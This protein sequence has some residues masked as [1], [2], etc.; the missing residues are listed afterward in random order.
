MA[1]KAASPGMAPALG[2][3]VARHAAPLTTSKSAPS[4]ACTPRL[5]SERAACTDWPVPMSRAINRSSALPPE[6]PST[7]EAAKAARAAA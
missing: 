4:T 2:S 6:S 1:A 5:T 7:A 3:A